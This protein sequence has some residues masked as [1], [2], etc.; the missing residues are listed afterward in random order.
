MLY[1]VDTFDQFPQFVV[2]NNKNNNNYFR[3]IVIH[4]IIKKWRTFDKRLK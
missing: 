4:N 3:N 2:H 1:Y